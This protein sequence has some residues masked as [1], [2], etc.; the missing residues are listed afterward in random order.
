MNQHTK[1]V[2]ARFGS[3]NDRLD[4]EYSYL[5]FEQNTY[6]EPRT[7]FQE[8]IDFLSVFNKGGIKYNFFSEKEDHRTCLVVKLSPKHKEKML[9]NILE[10]SLSKDLNL[11]M[12]DPP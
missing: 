2:F 1:S 7:R 8:I 3:I 12:Y 9:M 5:I 11:Y 6:G 4:P 10:L